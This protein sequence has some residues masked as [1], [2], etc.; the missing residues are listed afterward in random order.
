MAP[1]G[2]GGVTPTVAG[3]GVSDRGTPAP[4]AVRGGV[5][6]P[7]P[8]DAAAVAAAESHVGLDESAG[9]D[10]GTRLVADA[11]VAAGDVETLPACV[12]DD[13]VPSRHRSR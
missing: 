4:S 8:D 12:R 10:L 1:S 9:L 5:V 3:P 2:T 13:A 6:G 7:E 11:E